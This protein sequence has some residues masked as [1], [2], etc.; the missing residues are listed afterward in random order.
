MM[1]MRN[2]RSLSQGRGRTGRAI[3]ACAG[4]ATGLLAVGECWALTPASG[5]QGATFPPRAGGDTTDLLWHMLAATLIVLVLGTLAILVVKKVLP[6]I[7]RSSGKQIS[8]LETTFLGPR[9]AVHLLQVGSRKLLLA[10][11]PDGVV[12]LDD[13]TGAFSAN[14]AEVARSIDVEGEAEE[15]SSGSTNE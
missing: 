14:Y 15:A 10:S 7:K 12:R 6:R 8:V 2:L 9:K 11:S 4:I 1:G 5:P 13:V 3:K